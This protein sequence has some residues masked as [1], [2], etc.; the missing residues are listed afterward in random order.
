MTGNFK[1][2]GKWGQFDP[3][4]TVPYRVS[5]SKIDLFSECPRCAYLDMRC[6][7]KRPS[8][9]AFTLNN[10]VDE[11]FKREFD[12]YRAKKEPHPLMKAAGID[13]VPY[14]HKDLE[15]WRDSFKRGI[16]YHH[17]PTNITLRGGIDDVWVTPNGELIIVDYKATSKK[18]GPKTEDDLYDSYKRQM[19][20]YQWLFR[21]NGFSVSPT[22]YFVYANGDSNAKVF[23]NTLAFDTTFIPYKGDD[24][25]IEPTLVKLKDT[26]MSDEIPPVG[27]AFGGG[28]C[29]YCTYRE[30]AGKTLLNLYRAN[31]KK[32]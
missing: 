23:D 7:V 21:K 19:E 9:P 24:S 4:S 6:G 17:E 13:A 22:G 1:A 8:M 12:I 14:E 16:S 11:L 27:T 5:R 20:V 29:D 25:W 32:K 31:I 15:E 10:A 30:A 3:T 26:L 2:K 28:P 18:Q